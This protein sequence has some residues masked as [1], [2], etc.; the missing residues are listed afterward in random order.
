MN[1][2]TA[3][4]RLIARP[5]RQRGAVLYV[6]LIMLILLALL[7]IAGMQVASMQE[8]MASNYRAMNRSFQNT[9]GVVRA[10]EAAV[11]AVQDRTSVP[12]GSLVNDSNISQICDDTFDPVSWGRSQTTASV[13]VVTVRRIDI[14]VPG[15]A[16]GQFG[17]PINDR[18]TGTFQITGYAADNSSSATSASVVDTIFKY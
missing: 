5:S 4:S 15:E 1:R 14:C 10:A 17:G 2:R 11:K 6:A 7:G 18:A 9:E 16:D 13:P 8:R 3:Q 12:S